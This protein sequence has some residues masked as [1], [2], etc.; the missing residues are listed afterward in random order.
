MYLPSLALVSPASFF[1]A[2]PPPLA[3]IGG[4]EACIQLLLT[5]Q[6]LEVERRAADAAAFPGTFPKRNTHW[7]LSACHP[8]PNFLA[9]LAV[10][11]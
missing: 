1:F 5:Y 9:K 7:L 2:L 8:K 4:A 11:V 6:A 3:M 10:I